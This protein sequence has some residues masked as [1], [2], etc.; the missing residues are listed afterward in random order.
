M[1]TPPINKSLG[2]SPK[3]WSEEHAG[4][5]PGNIPIWVGILSE[6]TEFGIFLLPTLSRNFIMQIYF[7]KVGVF[8]GSCRLNC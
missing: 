7:P 4:R 3:S 8:Q 1:K 5:I 6:L 2:I